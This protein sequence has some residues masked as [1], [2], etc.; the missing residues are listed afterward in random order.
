MERY[1]IQS[2]IA[3]GSL[4]LSIAVISEY[5]F[6]LQA[7]LL[8]WFDCKLSLNGFVHGSFYCHCLT[9]YGYLCMIPSV[10]SRVPYHDGFVGKIHISGLNATEISVAVW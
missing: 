3:Y 4:T 7:Y 2:V 10:W 8:G 9:F 6:M 1:P 5:T